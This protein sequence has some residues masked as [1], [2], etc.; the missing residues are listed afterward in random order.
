MSTESKLSV[1]TQVVALVAAVVGA[2]AV[3]LWAGPCTG[4]LELA[5]GNMVPMRCA[6]TAK[7]AVLLFALAAGLSV[8]GLATK[9]RD[10]LAFVLLGVALFLVTFESAV[11]IGVCKSQME[12]WTMAAWIRGCGALVALCGMVNA[13][14]SV[15]K[16]QVR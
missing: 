6:Y 8:R 16:R 3:V 12:C 7:V 2:L 5:N 13:L 4:A 15:A 1:V 11:G 14:A 10:D 9:K